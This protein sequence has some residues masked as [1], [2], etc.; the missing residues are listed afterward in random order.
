MRVGTV[1]GSS[2]IP[3]FVR[4]VVPGLVFAVDGELGASEMVA[5]CPCPRLTLHV[6]AGVISAALSG[7]AFQRVLPRN[8]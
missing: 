6:S 8:G 2:L 4:T 1:V 3:V 7:M 5:G